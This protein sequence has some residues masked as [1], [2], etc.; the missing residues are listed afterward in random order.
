MHVAT[1]RDAGLRARDYRERIHLA[2]IADFDRPGAEEKSAPMDAR[3]L[4]SQAKSKCVL[5][6]DALRFGPLWAA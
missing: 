2:F 5:F 4:A 6:S 1:E 3:R